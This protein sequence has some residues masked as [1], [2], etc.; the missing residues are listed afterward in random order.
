MYIIWSKLPHLTCVSLAAEHDF[1][2]TQT[3]HINI[4]SDNHTDE[5]KYDRNKTQKTHQTIAVACRANDFGRKF[6]K[7]KLRIMNGT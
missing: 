4:A 3:P 2:P 6:P 7:A 5:T 1:H